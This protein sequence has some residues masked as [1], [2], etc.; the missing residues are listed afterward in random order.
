M[1]QNIKRLKDIGC[2]RGRRHIMVSPGMAAACSGVK[3]RADD[4]GS[5]SDHAHSNERTARLFTV[6]NGLLSVQLDS[7]GGLVCPTPTA[8]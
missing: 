6:V 8:A 4:H 7:S 2:Y 1:A 5:Q 3:H